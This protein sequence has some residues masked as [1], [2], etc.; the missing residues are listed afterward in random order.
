MNIFDCCW[1][2]GQL[3]RRQVSLSGSRNRSQS[4]IMHLSMLSRRVGVGGYPRE[5]NSESLPLGRDFGSSRCPRVGNL[6][7]PPSWK[8]EGTWKKVIH[9]HTH[10]PHNQPWFVFHLFLF[11]FPFNTL[12]LNHNW[13]YYISTIYHFLYVICIYLF[14]I[15]FFF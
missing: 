6:T 15:F 4:F 12:F 7:C 9:D 5:F 10:I 11:L 14:I 1:A 3:W 8:T 13:K 2:R